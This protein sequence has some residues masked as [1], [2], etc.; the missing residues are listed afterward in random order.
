MKKTKR[1]TAGDFLLPVRSA[2]DIDPALVLKG[3]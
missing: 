1:Y 2:T 3:E